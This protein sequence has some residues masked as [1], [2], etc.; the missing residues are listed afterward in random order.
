MEREPG[1]LQLRY[2]LWEGEHVDDIIVAEDEQTIVALA[3]VSTSWACDGS[4]PC[5]VPFHVYLERPLGGRAVIDGCGGKP[6]RYK[7]VY[8]TLAGRLTPPEC[9]PQELI[10]RGR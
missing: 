3:I 4:Q 9:L 1:R 7:N 10:P 2:V 6:V 5:E 8:A